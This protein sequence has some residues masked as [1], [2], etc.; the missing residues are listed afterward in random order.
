MSR[1]L[2][3]NIEVFCRPTGHVALIYDEAI[4]WD[5]LGNA[6]TYRASHV[7]PDGQ[8]GWTADLRPVGGDVLG[9]F[10]K[11]SEALAAE[12]DWLNARYLPQVST[13]P[14]V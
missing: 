13:P 11:R 9:P 3:E 12:R 6:K 10:M 5:A 7:E 8:G 14:A 2:A 4:A 1:Q